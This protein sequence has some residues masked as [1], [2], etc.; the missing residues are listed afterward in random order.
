M[1]WFKRDEEPRVP[2]YP[3]LY[4]S[5]DLLD[6]KRDKEKVRLKIEGKPVDAHTLADL[7]EQARFIQGSRMW[8]L[9]TKRLRVM[10][11]T[12]ALNT[13]KNW[14]E[15]IA[16]KAQADHVNLME[17]ILTATLEAQTE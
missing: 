1:R 8:G 15:V 5:D 10:A 13:S 17:A 6:F 12:Q 4:A 7:K 2:F 16:A 11:M 14:E 9:L 3:S